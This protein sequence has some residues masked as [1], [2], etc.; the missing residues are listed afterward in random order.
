MLT[1]YVF[2]LVVGAGLLI[3]SLFSDHGEH[4][5]EIHH[6]GPVHD[7]NPMEWFS[8]RTLMYFMFVFGGV[9]TALT[10]TWHGATAPLILILALVSGL[11]VGGLV[12]AAFRYLRT[13]S[14]GNRQPD[15]SFIGLTGTMTVPFGS[16]G[17]GKV[18]LTRGDRVFELLAR[19]FDA[20]R[21]DI[22]TWKS[23]T[24]LEMQ[25]G[26]AMVVPSDD[27]SARELSSLNP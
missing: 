21:D 23:V 13:S 14:S 4:D 20:S 19:P 10:K 7:A 9:G 17:A 26:T 25:R 5:A 16:G 15:E 1:L 24:V 22:S 18:L 11:G 6:G 8:V 3:F 27:P 2:A 12:S